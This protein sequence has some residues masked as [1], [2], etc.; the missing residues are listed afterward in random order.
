MK[1]MKNVIL[2]SLVVIVTTMSCNSNKNSGTRENGSA[3]LL[4]RQFIREAKQYEN[5]VFAAY[6][7]EKS[8]LTQYQVVMKTQAEIAKKANEFRV[9]ELNAITK[10]VAEEEGVDQNGIANIMALISG[11]Q[12]IQDPKTLE[13]EMNITAKSLY[14]E[15]KQAMD[16]RIELDRQYMDWL[17]SNKGFIAESRK[18]PTKKYVEAEMGKAVQT[19][20][21]KKIYE[22]KTI[23]ED[24]LKIFE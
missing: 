2:I 14:A 7:T 21:G 3:N 5:E 16:L 15:Y 22:D 4:E 1:K 18:Y 12:T 10:S 20:T 13:R 23:E 17:T 24:D 9:S 6:E 19:T 11:F 8:A